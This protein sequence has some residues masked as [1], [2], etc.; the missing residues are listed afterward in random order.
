MKFEN[1]I[2]LLVVLLVVLLAIPG[3]YKLFKKQ[4]DPESKQ[5]FLLPPPVQRT[6]AYNA[7]VPVPPTIR[8]VVPARTAAWV[9]SLVQDRTKA[10]Q[11]AMHG[12][13]TPGLEPMASR[14]QAFQVVAIERDGADLK[15]ALIIWNSDAPADP[16]AYELVADYPGATSRARVT[17]ASELDLPDAVRNE[18]QDNNFIDPPHKVVWLTAEVPLPAGAK[19]VV[20]MGFRLTFGTGRE[21][22]EGVTVNDA[23]SVAPEPPVTAMKVPPVGFPAAGFGGGG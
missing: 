6:I 18:L 3:G 14:Y 9:A 21:G 4:L 2:N 10:G 23:V 8:R 19:A 22:G 12:W 16:K 5:M 11:V 17:E 15:L 13:P 7:P 1:R 20:P